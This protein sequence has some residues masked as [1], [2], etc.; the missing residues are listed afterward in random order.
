MPAQRAICAALPLLARAGS[1]TLGLV[2][3]ERQSGLHGDEP[4]ADM[5]LY[6]ARHG[7]KVNVVVAHTRARESDALIDMAREVHAG[8]M[9]AGAF[10]HSR[11]RE[12]FLGGVTRD[13]LGSAPVPLL[14]AH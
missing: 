10:G 1:V 12:W 7:V 11:Y 9:V 14:I 8:L 6:L 13:L 2:N 5:A 4:G 3:P